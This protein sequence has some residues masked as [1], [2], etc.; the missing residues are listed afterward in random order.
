MTHACSVCGGFF[1]CNGGR[2]TDC[3][4]GS[5]RVPR[6]LRMCFNCAGNPNEVAHNQVVHIDIPPFPP[7]L[8]P[9]NL[10]AIFVKESELCRCNK[11]ELRHGKVVFV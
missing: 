1:Q 8:P 9:K 3:T 10:D 2:G 5:I 7:L 4:C 11:C 6:A